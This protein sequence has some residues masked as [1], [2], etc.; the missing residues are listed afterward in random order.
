MPEDL[1]VIELAINSFRIF[2]NIIVPDG[3]GQRRGFESELWPRT[4]IFIFE[5][6]P[7]DGNI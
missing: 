1:Q 5:E 3:G 6:L 4:C 7:D 2:G